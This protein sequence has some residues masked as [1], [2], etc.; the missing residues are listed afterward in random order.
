MPNT[1]VFENNFPSF[2]KN[3]PEFI[4]IDICDFS[5]ALQL[6]KNFGLSSDT[7]PVVLYLEHPTTITLG[8]RATPSN[9]I[10]L[11][12]KMLKKKNVQYYS[13]KRGGLATIHS[14]GQLVIY[15][16]LNLKKFNTSVKQFIKII[17]QTTCAVLN[18]LH[19]CCEIK[20]SGIYIKQKKCVSLGL[21]FQKGV[22]QHGL[23]INVNNDIKIFQWIKPCG[24]KN[25][26]ITRLKDHGVNISTEYLAKIW[27]QQFILHLNAENSSDLK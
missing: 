21:R 11:S 25:V 14:L 22:S 4:Y 15:P 13:I 19:L 10:L 24:E 8:Y 18:D 12:E 26:A 2:S 6:Q 7:K 3:N 17:L 16:V 1:S 5:K 23:A 9:D 20:N 27:H